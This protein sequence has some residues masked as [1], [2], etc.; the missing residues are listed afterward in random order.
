MNSTHPAHNGPA[1]SCIMVIFGATGDLTKRLLLPSLYNLAEAK[2]LPEKF[3]IFGFAADKLD[4]A[5]FR[6]HVAESLHEFVG[7]QADAGILSW[8]EQ[9]CYYSSGDFGNAAAFA[10]LKSELE[11][12]EGEQGTEGNR[13]FYFAVAPRFISEIAGQLNR[14]KLSC[15]EDGKWRRIV[16]EKPF[17]HDLQSAIQLNK[18]LQKVLDEKQ[19]FRIDHYLG[20]ETV[21]NLTVFRF[22]NSIFEPIWNRAHINNI[23]ITAAETVGV[24]HRGSYYESAGALRDMAPNHL[25]QLISLTAMEPPISFDADNMRSKQAEVMH[26]IQPIEP[27]DVDKMAVRGQ[28]RPGQIDGH[29]VP[30]YRDEPEVARDSCTETYVALKVMIDNWRWADVPFYLRTGKRLAKALTEIVV[31]FRRTPF[32][33]FRDTPVDSLENNHLIIRIQ[34][35]QGILLR[36]GV[37]APGPVT[38]VEQGNMEFDF[39]VNSM[40]LHGT[41]Y[42][43]LLHDCM[44]G[45]QTLFQRADM[46][47]A[48]WRMVQ[49]V[50]D[51]WQSCKGADFPNYAAGLEGPKAADD[52]LARDCRHWKPLKLS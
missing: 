29:D 30:G 25:A 52:L 32:V 6:K 11:K 12:A 51:A 9:R 18:D 1:G 33:L 3:A 41:G 38:T 2:L 46:V 13:L 20:K 24:E 28:Y 50:L 27:E 14:S 19:I 35:Q 40:A 36:F 39:S 15:E 26:A 10:E 4:T 7:E 17:G 23:Q 47:E 42:E 5:G 49:P 48:G 31:T 45:D 44:L 21:Q 22:A 34:P 8:L 43:R 37:K 16:A